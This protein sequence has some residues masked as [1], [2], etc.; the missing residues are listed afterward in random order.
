MTPELLETLK[1]TSRIRALAQRGLSPRRIAVE[2]ALSPMAVGRVL[3]RYPVLVR[4]PVQ[5]L[6][7]PDEPFWLDESD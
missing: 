5:D 6:G 1:R 7:W 2:L 3:A 4:V